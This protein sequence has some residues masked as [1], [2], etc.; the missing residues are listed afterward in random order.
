ME[1]R[2]QSPGSSPFPRSK[3]VE[4]DPIANLP[5][6]ENSVEI[7]KKDVIF[8]TKKNL[9]KRPTRVV[10]I[11]QDHVSPQDGGLVR[12]C[13]LCSGKNQCSMCSCKRQESFECGESKEIEYVTAQKAFSPEEFASEK[14]RFAKNSFALCKRCSFLKEWPLIT[15]ENDTIVT[16]FLSVNT[17]LLF[18]QAHKST[19][20]LSWG[21]EPQPALYRIEEENIRLKILEKV[22]SPS[23]TKDL[24]FYCGIEEPAKKEVK[25]ALVSILETEK[26]RDFI[27]MASGRVSNIALQAKIREL[28]QNDLLLTISKLSPQ[29]FFYLAKHK[30]GTYVIQLIIGMIKDDLLIEEIKRHISPYSTALLQ[31]EIGNY[32]VQRIIDFDKKFVYSCFMKDFER[33]VSTKIGSRA[34]KSCIKHFCAYKKEIIAV[35]SSD[36][37]TAIPFEEQ[38]VLKAALKE[39]LSVSDRAV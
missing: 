7:K 11:S 22:F 14:K 30:Y 32:V 12:L 39:L 24:E 16:K 5:L 34:F 33:I 23:R 37:Q 29:V 36:F 38:K 19:L 25:P 9:I 10:R 17:A 31:H 6:M 15:W 35:L 13:F 1:V 18:Y 21:Y 2:A 27:C 20:S 8:E 28:S 3:E 4:I 26:S